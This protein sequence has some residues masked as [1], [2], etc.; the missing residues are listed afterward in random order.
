VFVTLGLLC[1]VAA[2][3][4]WARAERAIRCNEPL[5]ASNVGVAVAAVVAVSA[6]ALL[7]AWLLA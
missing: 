5:P 2:W 6:L 1:A 4:R 3:V 7:A